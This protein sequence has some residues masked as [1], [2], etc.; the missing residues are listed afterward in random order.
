MSLMGGLDNFIA[1]HNIEKSF[2]LKRKINKPP[3]SAQKNKG[4]SNSYISLQSSSLFLSP[5]PAA[6]TAT[7]SLWTLRQ[8]D[9]TLLP[10]GAGA[11][12]LSRLPAVGGC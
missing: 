1:S 9:S 11:R 5:G 7:S 3:S 4:I 2:T 8:P 10:A 12:R 6:V